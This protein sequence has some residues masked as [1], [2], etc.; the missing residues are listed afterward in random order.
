MRILYS[1]LSLFPKRTHIA[2]SRG[3]DPSVSFRCT[4]TPAIQTPSHQIWQPRRAQSP[5][6]PTDSP[7]FASGET[8]P[9]IPSPVQHLVLFLTV[10]APE[11]PVALS[12]TTKDLATPCKH[13]WGDNKMTSSKFARTAKATN[14]TG[15]IEAKNARCVT[16]FASKTAQ[17]GAHG[18]ISCRMR[19]TSCD[20]CLDLSQNA[21]FLLSERPRER[22]ASRSGTSRSPTLVA[23]EASATYAPPMEA[24]VASM[25]GGEGATA[26]WRSPS[27]SGRAPPSLAADHSEMHLSAAPQGRSLNVASSKS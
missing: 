22:P 19:R 27:P 5:Q 10:I 6:F 11:K 23:H 7:Q 3:A 12:A 15:A 13:R 4:S 25:M 18:P 16:D 1:Y 21:H 9:H 8:S 17:K 2:V 20:F 26:T 14:K 24:N